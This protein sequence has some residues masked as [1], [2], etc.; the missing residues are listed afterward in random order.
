MKNI[1]VS[2]SLMCADQL[3]IGKEAEK[4]AQSGADLLHIDIMDGVFVPNIQLGTELV[5]AVKRV[6]KLPLD[7]HLMITEPEKKLGMF[8]FGP[9]DIVSVHYEATPHPIRALQAVKD[10]GARPFIALNPATPLEVL[11]DMLY[12]V[13]GVLLMA[14]NPGFAGQSVIPSAFDK[15]ARL[16]AM[17]ERAGRRDVKIEI[18]GNVSFENGERFV[19]CGADILV[20]GSSCLFRK[21]TEYSQAVKTL[22]TYSM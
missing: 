19:K 10:R 14:V 5:R 21:G 22:K 2:P 1:L 4:L 9:G 12:I 6:S 3:S 15:T 7:I 16:S 8:E 20:A 17:L 18:D 13:D 11:C